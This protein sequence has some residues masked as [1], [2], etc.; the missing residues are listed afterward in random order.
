MERTAESKEKLFKSMSVNS[1]NVYWE[2]G[3]GGSLEMFSRNDFS[4]QYRQIK[5]LEMIEQDREVV[6]SIT[7]SFKLVINPS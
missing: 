6:I 2:S 4:D 7:S 1:L 5:L 3:K